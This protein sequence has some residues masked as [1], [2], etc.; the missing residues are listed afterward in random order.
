M[1]VTDD[2]TWPLPVRSEWLSVSVTKLQVA[3]GLVS[4]VDAEDVRELLHVTEWLP[5]PQSR[6]EHLLLRGLLL[7]FACRSGSLL[8]ARMHHERSTLCAFVPATL[9]HQF[10]SDITPD[11]R[12]AFAR[13]ARA[14]YTALSRTHRPSAASRAAT[15][16]REHFT[17]SW[18]VR[19]LAKEVHAPAGQFRRE[20]LGEFGVSV[21]EYQ[22]TIRILEALGQIGD[23]KIEAIV[24]TVGYGSKKNF[25]RT[26]RKLVGLSPRTFR[27]LPAQEAETIRESVADVLSRRKTRR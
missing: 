21:R 2:H 8:H 6:T 19:T 4:L 27:D 5:D 13:W 23:E 9:L 18:S 16:V 24:R 15:L 25:Y 11:A 26:F 7:E 17:T 12:V 14:F 1:K 10:W 3:S 22:Q 20:F